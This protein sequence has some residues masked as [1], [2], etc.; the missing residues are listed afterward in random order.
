MG[1][2][3][4]QV[5]GLDVKKV[6]LATHYIESQKLG[7]LESELIKSKTNDE[8]DKILNAFSSDPQSSDT[9]LDQFL[10]KIKVCF[11]GE[12]VEKIYENLMQDDSDWAQSTLKVLNRMSPCSL[13]VVHRSLPNAK[14][15]SLRDCLRMEFRLLIHHNEKSDLKEGARAVLIEK[16]FKPK[17]SHKSIYEVTEEDV[18]RFFQPSPDGDELLL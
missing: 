13:K 5:K 10:P 14:T 4:T 1:L 2:T 9:K 18:A 8:V 3:G 17:W 16:D 7:E 6:G 12:T 15:L 11:D